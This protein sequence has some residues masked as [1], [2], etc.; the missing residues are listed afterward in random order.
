MGEE[1]LEEEG[2][3]WAV[4]ASLEEEGTQVV[5]WEQ[6]KLVASADETCRGLIQT[7][8]NEFLEQRSMVGDSLKQL[9]GMKEELYEVEEVPFL[10]GK[11]LVPAGLRA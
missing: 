2:M 8:R 10:H 4:R 9:F 7:I 3:V 5:T 11:M 6:V 1:A